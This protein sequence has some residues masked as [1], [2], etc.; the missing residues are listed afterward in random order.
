MFQHMHILGVI[1]L[2]WRQRC[3]SRPALALRW[4]Q[5]CRM[6]RTRLQ[7]PAVEPAR[8]SCDRVDLGY[9]GRVWRKPVRHS[10]ARRIGGTE[11]CDADADAS[12]WHDAITGRSCEVR[13]L[14]SGNLFER[15]VWL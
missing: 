7:L 10:V 12:P 1:P 11:D 4:R 14:S 5:R 15:R 2:R 6:P 8:T 13:R 3:A 9:R